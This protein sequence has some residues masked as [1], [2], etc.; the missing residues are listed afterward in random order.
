MPRGTDDVLVGLD[1]ELFAPGLLHELKQPLMGAEAA[2][3]L[4]ERSL[5]SS[6]EAVEEWRMLRGQV[7]RIAEIVSGYEE[8][9][10]PQGSVPEPFEVGPVVGRSV[11]L[12]AHRVRPLGPRFA[13]ALGP[14]RLAGFGRPTALVHAAT[15]LLANALDAIEDA[16]GARVEVRVLEQGAGAV[17]VRVSDEGAGVPSEARPRIFEARFTTKAPGK[18]TGLGLHI[19]R[20]LMAQ[21]GGRVYLVPEE[22]PARLPW[23]V[24]EFCVVVPAS[25]AGGAP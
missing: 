17:E 25:A 8:L 12:L 24:T 7:A 14:G 9:L 19:A 1:A 23:A 20:S 18:G 10:R 3:T 11:E 6:L 5:G 15:N 2:L 13:L 21:D 22:D 16:P 4:L